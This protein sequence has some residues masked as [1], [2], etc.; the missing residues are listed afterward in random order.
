MR[1]SGRAKWRKS[2]RSGSQGECVEVGY[3]RRPGW[4]KSSRS[5]GQNGQCV[6]VAH[7][8]GVG[9][10]KSSRSAGNAACVEVGYSPDH[11]WRKSSQSSGQ[12][13]ECVEVGAVECF[14]ALRDSKNPGGPVLLI[15]PSAFTS[16]IRSVKAGRL[17]L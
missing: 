1:A 15:N 17:D 4:R 2:T 14:T 16:L 9:W 13:G 5:S 7:L 8:A 11:G 10:R 12:N 3:L 6:E